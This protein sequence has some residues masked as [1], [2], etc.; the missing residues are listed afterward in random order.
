MRWCVIHHPELASTSVVAE[1]ALQEHRWRG[2][3]R[4]SDWSDNVD[5][6]RADLA[7]GEVALSADLGDLDEPAPVPA[8]K[9][10]SKTEPEKGSS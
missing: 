3:R 6:L 7:R 9:A 1:D 4:V 5:D 10:G 2:W 8:K